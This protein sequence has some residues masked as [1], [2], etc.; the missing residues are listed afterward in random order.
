MTSVFSHVAHGPVGDGTLTYF[1]GIS[2]YNP[3]PYPVDATVWIHR[4]DGTLTGTD[5]LDLAANSRFIGLISNIIPDAWPQLGG[6]VVLSCTGPV[7][8]FELFVDNNSRMLSAVPR[9]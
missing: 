6:Y 4:Q 3:N 9:N 7:V 5:T 2:I 8:A 1:N